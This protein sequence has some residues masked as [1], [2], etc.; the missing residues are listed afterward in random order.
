MARKIWPLAI[1]VLSACQGMPATAPGMSSGASAPNA[2][3]LARSA[4]EAEIA[5]NLA[6]PLRLSFPVTVAVALPAADPS[7]LSAADL[8]ARIEQ[9]F[10]RLVAKGDV[11][12]VS[13]IP[14]SF[15]QGLGSFDGLRR[16]AAELGCEA[17][18]SV[19]VSR[20]IANDGP[21]GG[22]FDGA[23]QVRVIERLQAVGVGTRTG[24][25]FR[26]LAESGEAGPQ[27]LDPSR[28][29]YFTDLAA[30]T[31]RSADTAFARF[32]DGLEKAFTAIRE[33]GAPTPSP[34]PSPSPTPSPSPSP[35]S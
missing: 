13:Y 23:R 6:N 18:W 14:A 5:T 12:K 10:S 9:V 28:A 35:A 1:L 3:W 31:A 17:V 25:F 26:P 29:G 34:S 30:L 16:T 21:A 20:E 27:A 11:A 24:Q 4:Q 33:N 8:R 32:G 19:S 7:G 15:S 2:D 22:W